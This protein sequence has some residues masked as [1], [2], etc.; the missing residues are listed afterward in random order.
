MMETFITF[1]IFIAMTSIFVIH[2]YWMK[3]GV[4][5][6]KNY[7]DLVDKVLGIGNTLPS[8]RDFYFVNTFFILMAIFPLCKYFSWG[9][10]EEKYFKY[11]S[12]F[13]AIVF[14]IR[15]STIFFPKIIGKANKKFRELNRKVYTPLCLALGCGYFY[16]YMI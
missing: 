14:F 10:V 4:W 5:P 16:L 3:G 9:V 2:L 11:I 12:L 15:A 1:F 13:F 6:G 7:Q 8:K